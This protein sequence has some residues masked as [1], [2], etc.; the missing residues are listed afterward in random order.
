M[1]FNLQKARDI[2]F[3]FMKSKYKKHVAWLKT[4][5][6]FGMTVG[7]LTL[8]WNKAKRGEV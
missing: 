8:V 1:L 3:G 2:Y 7:Q 4:A 6:H 5:E